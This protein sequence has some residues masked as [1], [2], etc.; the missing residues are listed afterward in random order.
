MDMMVHHSELTFLSLTKGPLT[1]PGTCFRC[2]AVFIVLVPQQLLS[3]FMLISV[4]DKP[5]RSLCTE[6]PH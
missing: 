5:I 3:L 6:S 4:W 2:F 1:R